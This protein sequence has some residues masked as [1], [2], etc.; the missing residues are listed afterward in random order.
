MSDIPK[1]FSRRDFL[2]LAGLAAAAKVAAACGFPP[3][4]VPEPTVIPPG[5][6]PTIVPDVE[7]EV[8][9]KIKRASY[10]IELVPRVPIEER[11]EIRAVLSS[12]LRVFA[13]EDGMTHVYLMPGLSKADEEY[14]NGKGDEWG[15]NGSIGT[16]KVFKKNGVWFLRE[17]STP[18]PVGGDQILGIAEGVAQEFFL[19]FGWDGKTKLYEVGDKGL[20]FDREGNIVL[21]RSA[22]GQL[23]APEIKSFVESITTLVPVEAG[24]ERKLTE[25]QMRKYEEVVRIYESNGIK[26]NKTPEYILDH[27]LGE[28]E[29]KFD[30]G[31]LKLHMTAEE[32]EKYGKPVAQLLY[33]MYGEKGTELVFDVMMSDEPGAVASYSGGKA[34]DGSLYSVLNI[35]RVWGW[36]RE[37]GGYTRDALGVIAHE[38]GHGAEFR[39]EPMSVDEGLEWEK[40]RAELVFLFGTKGVIEQY[41]NW[42]NT[43]NNDVGE[44]RKTNYYAQV[45]EEVYVNIDLYAPV[46]SWIR[47]KIDILGESNVESNFLLGGFVLKTKAENPGMEMTPEMWKLYSDKMLSMA[48]ETFADAR[49]GT[50][51]DAVTSFANNTQADELVG[52]MLG[53]EG[54]SVG[55]KEIKNR[56][57]SGLNPD[58]PAVKY[59]VVGVE[60]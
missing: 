44:E 17:V 38:L 12:L 7:I 37:G 43:L 45:G 28:G 5:I 54:S 50:V 16:A 20:V 23:M 2:R 21:A 33:L 42:Y 30:P 15:V 34:G 57:L 14:L 56:W 59:E 60:G 8:V 52:Q 22:D 9:G 35:H 24:E 11:Q 46:G 25:E 31:V 27:Y 41:N 47:D 3:R 49:K 40:L 48:V 6:E 29:T 36:V 32:A 26:W 4:P 18:N 39:P 10:S 13:S 53:I 55:L 19:T 58:S 51:A 1:S